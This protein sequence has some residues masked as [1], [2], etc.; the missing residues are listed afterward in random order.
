[1]MFEEH[2]DIWL[3]KLCFG[4]ESALFWTKLAGKL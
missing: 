2:L 4:M 3:E 1:M